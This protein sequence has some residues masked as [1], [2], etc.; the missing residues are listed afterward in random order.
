[1]W[2][3]P[4]LKIVPIKSTAFSSLMTV[5][6]CL[7]KTVGRILSLLLLEKEIK[8]ISSVE[9]FHLSQVFKYK[10]RNQWA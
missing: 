6:S 3:H 10:D 1:M 8:V 4:Q 7:T 5:S 2:I 9:P